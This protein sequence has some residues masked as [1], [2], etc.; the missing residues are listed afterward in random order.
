MQDVNDSPVLRNVGANLREFRKQAGMSQEVLAQRSG[1]SR[2]T[3]INLEAGEANVS[4]ASL[5]YLAEALKVR[6]VDLVSAPATPHS[7][8]NEL[9]WRGG[10]SESRAMLLGSAAAS[11]EVQ[12]WTW[13]LARGARYDAEPDPSGWSEMVL[14]AEGKLRIEF[15]DASLELGAGE[16]ATYSSAQYYS[17]VNAGSETVRFVRNVIC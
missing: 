6:F 5:D 4:L 8:I 1:V 10:D 12:L 11:Q 13:S 15:S 9:A 17:Y 3:I 2:R 14:V 16:H 7:K